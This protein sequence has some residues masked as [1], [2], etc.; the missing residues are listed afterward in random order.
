MGEAQTRS[1]SDGS[2]HTESS[3]L[4]NADGTPT[5][6]PFVHRAG[7]YAQEKTS[8]LIHVATCSTH[9]LVLALGNFNNS[10]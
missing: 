4:T 6:H 8:K 3:F 1:S 2:E 7:C 9:F 5:L 10:E